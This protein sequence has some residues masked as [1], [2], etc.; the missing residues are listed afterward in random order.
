MPPFSTKKLSRM[1]AHGAKQSSRIVV[2]NNE[3]ASDTYL[4][5]YINSQ[6]RQGA[7]F[8]EVCVYEKGIVRQILKKQQEV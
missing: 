5:R 1:L 6:I 3:G 8:D 2:N 4:C 7:I